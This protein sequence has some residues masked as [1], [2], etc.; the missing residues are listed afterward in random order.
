M[1]EKFAP[2]AEKFIAPVLTAAALSS[3]PACGDD[4]NCKDGYEYVAVANQCLEKCNKVVSGDG[5]LVQ[6]PAVNN[7]EICV[8]RK[9]VPRY[10]GQQP[11]SGSTSTSSETSTNSTSSTDSTSTSTNSSG[12]PCHFTVESDDMAFL[13][14]KPYTDSNNV[15]HKGHFIDA[16]TRIDGDFT[17][18]LSFVTTLQNRVKFVIDSQGSL[19]NYDA[20]PWLDGSA[21][22]WEEAGLQTRMNKI[23]NMKKLDQN[24]ADFPGQYTSIATI[25]HCNK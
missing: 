4:N 11:D 9:D 25:V 6:N 2:K 24:I 1:F 8:E 5:F 10:F 14:N 16:A 21:N 19:Q 18:D 13:D 3:A 23:G 7:D 12:E 15:E 17:G 22:D 20:S